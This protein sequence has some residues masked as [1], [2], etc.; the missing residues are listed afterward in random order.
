VVSLDD[1]RKALAVAL[2]ILSAIE[3]HSRRAGLVSAG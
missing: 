1:G 3:Q 2:E